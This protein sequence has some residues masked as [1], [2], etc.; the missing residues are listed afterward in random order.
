MRPRGPRNFAAILTLPLAAGLAVLAS[1]LPLSNATAAAAAVVPLSEL[2]GWGAVK[3]INVSSGGGTAPPST[4]PSPSPV[5]SA[6]V[7]DLFGN[8]GEDVVAAF[9]NGTVYAWTA[10]G[11]LLPGWPKYTGGPVTGSPTLADL[12]GNGQEDVIVA[13]H[14]GWVNVW[15]PSG[16]AYPGW[17]KYVAAPATDH[18]PVGFYG[19]VAV[20]DLF[21]NG[22]LDLVASSWDHFLYAWSASGSLLPGFPINLYD[23]SWDT[24]AL[25]DLQGT[26]QLDIVVGSDSIGPPTEPCAQG[27]CY[28]AFTPQGSLISGWR[29]SIGQVPWSSPAVADL[30]GNGSM[31]TVAGT[32]FYYP[33]PAGN[34]DYVF[35]SSGGIAMQLPTVAQN[36][37]SP[38]IGDVLGNGT[39]QI[40]QVTGR[41]A[42]GTY[43]WNSA[44]Q[45]LP[46]WGPNYGA[47][48]NQ[49]SSA[50]IAPVDGSGVNGVWLSM[51]GQVI[52]WN[53][54]GNEVAI[55]TD[56]GTQAAVYSTPTIASL[57]G[58]TLDVVS[59]AQADVSSNTSW[60]VNVFPIPGTNGNMPQ[61]AWPTF[62][63]NMQRSGTP[64]IFTSANALP[65]TENSTVFTVSWPA[66]PTPLYTVYSSENGGPWLVWTNTG[67]TAENFYGQPGNTYSFYVQADENGPPPTSATPPQTTTTVS[68]AATVVMPFTGMYTAGINGSVRPGSSQPLPYSGT[69]PGMNVVRAIA[70]DPNGLGGYTL[71]YGGGV[72]PFGDKIGVGPATNA[73]WSFDIARGIAVNPSNTNQGYVLDGYGG[74]HP[75]GGAPPV[76]VTAYW[77]GWDIATGIELLPNGASGYVL[78]GE[79]GLHPFAACSN[80]TTTGAPPASP[81]YTVPLP[82]ILPRCCQWPFNIARGFALIASGP[83][84][85]SG[86]YIVDGLGNIHPF[87]S[88][89]PVQPSA[90]WNYDIVRGIALIP[91]SSSEGYTVDGWGHYWPFGGAPVVTAAIVTPG[92]YDRG[93]GIGG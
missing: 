75:F 88:A 6:A 46:G 44:G 51:G 67:A 64:A 35:N 4:D 80:P 16:A 42:T 2:S 33:E 30:N 72:H 65:S 91:G 74:V 76:C 13:S 92:N 11:N 73:F 18:F 93:I 39:N 63:G 9:P 61:G 21:G 40:V 31:E 19:S 82:N 62:H 34:E 43:I 48:A 47:T 66:A 56:A 84:T 49:F 41:T 69:W 85:A 78:D 12:S 15:T 14:S 7:G 38:A 87:G 5:A 60:T 17:P 37:S 24:P 32:G 53:A 58:G 1:A 26:G 10:A 90:T 29:T 79:G 55:G 20:G 27:G 83:Y 45:P 36:F 70:V 77:P 22:Q 71:D 89:V 68:P 50:A 8:G 86:G 28:W 3:T 54:A 81:Q 59:I 57:G 23:T 25:A 52:G